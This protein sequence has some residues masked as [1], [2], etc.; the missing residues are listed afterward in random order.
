MSVPRHRSG[1]VG[2]AFQP[3]SLAAKSQAGKPDLLIPRAPFAEAQLVETRYDHDALIQRA[4]SAVA[5][6]REKCAHAK[7]LQEVSTELRS[8]GSTVCR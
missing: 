1:F 8:S 6:A 3:D 5:A 7:A 2:Q 4:R